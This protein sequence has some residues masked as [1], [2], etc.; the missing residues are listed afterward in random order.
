MRELNRP[1]LGSLEAQTANYTATTSP[2]PDRLI[3]KCR[4]LVKLVLMF[5]LIVIRALLMILAL[6]VLAIMSFTAGLGW[7][8]HTP[9][10]DTALPAAYKEV[11][12]KCA[13]NTFSIRNGHHCRAR[14]QLQSLRPF[15]YCRPLE[16][17]MPAWRR[18]IVTVS[19]NCAGFVM[20]ML[21]FRMRVR[22]LENH[23]KAKELGAVSS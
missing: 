11:S 13:R 22:G 7:W 9:S 16:E 19:A 20:L 14:I 10:H 23:K 5:P 12:S 18:R 2:F 15:M 6:L 21:G 3:F 17:P 1:A 4:E 8:E